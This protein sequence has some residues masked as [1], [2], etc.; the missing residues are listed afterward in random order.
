MAELPEEIRRLIGNK[1]D[2]VARE[3]DGLVAHL[4]LSSEE[5]EFA[6]ATRAKS[7]ICSPIILLTPTPQFNVPAPQLLPRSLPLRCFE[8]GQTM[9]R[10]PAINKCLEM[11][12]ALTHSSVKRLRWLTR[13]EP[14]KTAE[15][16]V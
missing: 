12:N 8:L 7:L 2:D 1:T 3:I 9:M 11:L 15:L 6:A 14:S 10:R 16:D 13:Q 5:E 4:D